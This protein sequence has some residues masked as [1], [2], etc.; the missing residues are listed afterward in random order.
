MELPFLS[1]EIFLVLKWKI[2]VYWRLFSVSGLLFASVE[3]KKNAGV[4]FHCIN[5]SVLTG[6]ICPTNLRGTV[7]DGKA[8][9]G[10]VRVVITGVGAISLTLKP[11]Y[12]L[13]LEVKCLVCK[14]MLLLVEL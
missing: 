4:V 8:R 1:S 10:A 7:S 5:S 2:G 14:C 11:I 6:L 13:V 3:C 12:F 9:L